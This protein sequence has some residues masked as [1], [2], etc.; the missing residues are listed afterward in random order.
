MI[1]LGFLV[2]LLSKFYFTSCFLVS[3]VF[4]EFDGFPMSLEDKRRLAFFSLKT[5]FFFALTLNNQK[6]TCRY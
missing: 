5:D 1:S 3:A 4:N 6:I 2:Y